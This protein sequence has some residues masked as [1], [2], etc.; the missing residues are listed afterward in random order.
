MKSKW[1]CFEKS[2]SCSC[3]CFP[4]DGAV[5]LQ[6]GKSLHWAFE[7]I[8]QHVTLALRLITS[9]LLDPDFSVGFIMLIQFY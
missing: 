3:A 9:I 8:W 4:L 5:T 1:L 6:R 2:R 7:K